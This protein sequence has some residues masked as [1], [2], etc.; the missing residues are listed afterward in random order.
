MSFSRLRLL[1]IRRIQM[2]CGIDSENMIA[3]GAI[4][5]PRNMTEDNVFEDAV[6]EYIHNTKERENEPKMRLVESCI[7][8]R[9]K[10]KILGIILPNNMILWWV[11]FRIYDS[12]L[13][14]EIEKGNITAF[15]VAL[16]SKEPINK[17]NPY[18]DPKNGR[19]TSAA[20]SGNA[21]SDV[22]NSGDSDI[23]D[24]DSGKAFNH[25]TLKPPKK[26]YGKVIHEI[27][28]M[29]DTKFKGKTYGTLYTAVGNSYHEYLF[30]IR[31]FDDYNIYY[32]E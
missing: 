14:G 24:D 6:Y 22:D 17:Y 8:T 32:K 20:G 16:E 1:T 27:N 31:G 7:L 15:S 26:E 21:K 2:I 4:A 19:F 25:T 12:A 11:G 18:H 9:E 3:F 30:E 28:T 23:I 13:W 10:Q 29:Y 5:I